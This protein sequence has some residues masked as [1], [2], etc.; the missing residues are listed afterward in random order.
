MLWRGSVDIEER[1]WRE[2]VRE[3]VLLVVG[4]VAPGG[5]MEMVYG[6]MYTVFFYVYTQCEVDKERVFEGG[7]TDLCPLGA[8]TIR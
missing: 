1:I 7:A 3:G 6:L 2:G 5:K 4:E 8:L